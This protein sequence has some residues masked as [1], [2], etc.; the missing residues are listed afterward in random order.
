MWR[1]TDRSNNECE[2]VADALERTASRAGQF[3]TGSTVVDQL[4]PAA[5]EHFDSC[6]ACRAFAADLTEVRALMEADQGKT[7]P[8][9][10]F[11][12]RVMAS[13]AE[14]EAQLEKSAQTWAA[15]PRLAYRLSVL[16][17]LGLLIAASWVYE[18]PKPYNSAGLNSQQNAEGLA[19][20]G[21][22]QDDLLVG[23][24]SR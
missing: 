3:F 9:P 23:S 6:E 14:R 11:L 2:A 17:S 21:A 19:D 13:I 7:Q 15:V 5:R 24:V 18:M 12:S 8:G 4:S 22:L 10:F 16:A 20:P 1:I